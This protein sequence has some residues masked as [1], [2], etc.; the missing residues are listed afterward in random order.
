[1]TSSEPIVPLN[2]DV[3]DAISSRSDKG[4]DGDGDG[5]SFNSFL[6]FVSSKSDDGKSVAGSDTGSYNSF[7]RFIQTDAGKEDSIRVVKGQ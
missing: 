1:M 7:L 5:A 4:T 6:N 2:E 3:P